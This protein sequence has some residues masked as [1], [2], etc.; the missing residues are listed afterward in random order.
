MGHVVR[1]HRDN[2]PCQGE[3]CAWKDQE[4]MHLQ[5]QEFGIP[6]VWDVTAFTY[7]EAAEHLTRTFSGNGG[8][9]PSI[10]HLNDQDHQVESWWF[11]EA[12][13]KHIDGND[14]D[15][16][17]LVHR[18]DVNTERLLTLL[19]KVSAAEQDV[20]GRPGTMIDALKDALEEALGQ[21][22]VEACD[23]CFTPAMDSMK[24]PNLKRT[25]LDCCGEA[26]H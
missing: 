3:T 10:R 2:T 15:A 14:N 17:E 23:T 1:R 6:M 25:C 13:L 9:L 18:E 24:C 12:R 16:F 19:D 22:G 26:D 11:P 5:P 4:G 21:L 20:N 8:L 7:D